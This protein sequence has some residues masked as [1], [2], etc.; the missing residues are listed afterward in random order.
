MTDDWKRCPDCQDMIKR[1]RKEELVL[2]C[3]LEKVVI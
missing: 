2:L 1:L 3:G